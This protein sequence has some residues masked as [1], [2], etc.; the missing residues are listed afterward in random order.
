MNISCAVWATTNWAGVSSF[1]LHTLTQADQLEII[2]ALKSAN[3]KVIR[4]F[5]SQVNAGSKGSSA[6]NVNDLG[7]WWFR[8]KTHISTVPMT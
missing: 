3:V 8:S 7:K 4:I 2:A 1:F 6:V 5:I